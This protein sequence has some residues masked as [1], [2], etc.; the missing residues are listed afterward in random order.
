MARE[1][2]FVELFVSLCTAQHLR[3]TGFCTDTRTSSDSADGGTVRSH[4]QGSAH[5]W[6][7]LLVGPGDSSS[8][9]NTW[10][11]F[12]RVSRC[13]SAMLFPVAHSCRLAHPLNLCLYQAQLAC[14]K[15]PLT[16]F[17]AKHSGTWPPCT[18]IILPHAGCISLLSRTDSLLSTMLRAVY[19]N[20]VS[21]RKIGG[22]LQ[23]AQ[24]H[25]RH[26]ASPVA[27]GEP[28]LDA[29]PAQLLYELPSGKSCHP[30]A[31][32]PTMT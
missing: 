32:S 16:S 31:Q 27:L 6:R 21:E 1:T 14:Q 15:R 17:L 11:A 26:W 25:A 19:L 20:G 18:S 7:M 28:P 3:W 29:E 2:P 22:E 23:V 9:L 5:T 8:H 10:A 30:R 13:G 12:G 24:P 4:C